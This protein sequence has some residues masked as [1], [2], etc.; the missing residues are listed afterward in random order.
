MRT[1]EEQAIST[2]IVKLMQGVVY[3]E[4][5]EEVWRTI[6][7]HTAAVNDHFAAIGIRV[8][9]DP[10]EG[11]VYLKTEEP[12]EGEEPLPRLIVRRTLSY[13]VSLL[14]LLLRRRLAEFEAAGDEGK[15][16]LEREQIVEMLRVF[17]GETTNEARL[18]QNVDR[19]ITQVAKLGFIQ[20]LRGERG[21]GN[22]Q[23]RRILK[24]YIDA[25]TISDFQG[26]LDEYARNAQVEGDA[27]A[28]G[29]SG[30]VTGSS[31]SPADPRDPTRSA[32]D[33]WGDD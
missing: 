24:A 10:I 30:L 4:N 21:R 27:S 29:T 16:V 11:Y 20:E 31:G 6:E 17:L 28:A 32:D 23:V 9:S 18:L 19:T 1:P 3:R 15:L 7:R 33:G 13:H 2:A 22:W 25:E 14:L 8:I 5:H 12:E 26:K